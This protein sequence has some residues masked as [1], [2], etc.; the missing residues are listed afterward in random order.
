[1]AGAR[2]AR[3]SA[4]TW[5]ATRPGG[6][7]SRSRRASA[8]RG[9][10]P[11]IRA[12]RAPATS[13][14]RRAAW[15]SAATP[16]AGLARS[17]GR[18]RHHRQRPGHARL[19]RSHRALSRDRSL[20]VSAGPGVT[21]VDDDYTM[22]FFG[23]SAEQAASSTL[24]AMK[25]GGVHAVRF[26]V[27]ADYR[28]DPRGAWAGVSAPRACTATPRR[29]RSRATAPRISRRSSSVTVSRVVSEVFCA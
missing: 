27:N 16:G 1:M 21:W 7:A 9:A 23:V 3:D 11:T 2:A 12:W 6:S 13:T 25:R 19:L 10:S 26:G 29:A 4:S 17:S 15:S 24:P 18:D 5:C 8:A 22:T 28:F 20:T 14:A